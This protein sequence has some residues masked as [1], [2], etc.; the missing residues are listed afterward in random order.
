MQDF[1]I[2]TCL[3]YSLKVADVIVMNKLKKKL[4]EIDKRC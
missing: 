4:G 1:D 2:D 3:R